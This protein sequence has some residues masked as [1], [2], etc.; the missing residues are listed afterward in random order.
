M[1][2]NSLDSDVVPDAVPDILTFDGDTDARS[3]EEHPGG[4]QSFDDLPN[5]MRMWLP[6]E[7]KQKHADVLI[8]YAEQ[9]QSD[10]KKLQQEVNAMEFSLETGEVISA[11]ACL[12]EDYAMCGLIN[13]HVDWLEH[14][15][16]YS[17][18]ICALFTNEFL[19]DPPLKEMANASFWESV[20]EPDKEYCFIPV[21]PSDPR[22]ENPP[23]RWSPYFRQIKPLCM[24]RDRWVSCM[25]AAVWDRLGSRLEREK[26]QR[27]EQLEYIRSNRPDLLAVH[28]PHSSATTDDSGDLLTDDSHS[29]ADGHVTAASDLQTHHNYSCNSAVNLDANADEQHMANSDEVGAHVSHLVPDASDAAATSGNQSADIFEILLFAATFGIIFLTF[30]RPTQT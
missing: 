17:T 29:T 11:R 12:H 30:F 24:Y 6:P 23:M 10:A 21:L 16:K 2:E 27:R 9:D 18:L 26:S 13:R 28:P 22:L 20:N 7:L 15:L 8:V 14:A 3:T 1:L 25:R 5:E 4:L 19:R